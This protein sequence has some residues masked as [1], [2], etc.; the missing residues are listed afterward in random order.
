MPLAQALADFQADVQQ[1][2]SLVAHAHAT[3]PAGQSLLP[4]SDRRQITAAALLNMF[5]AWETF[6]E[7]ALAIFMTGGAT[8]GGAQPTKFVSPPSEE[9]AQSMVIGVNRYF[10]YGN[11]DFFRKLVSIYFL[12]GYPFEP[13]MAAIS[14]DLADLRTL[15]NASAHITSTTQQALE[16]LYLRI[17][18]TPNPGVDL[19]SF[20]LSLDPR[21]NAN[22]TVFLAYRNKLVV[23]AQLIAYG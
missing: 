15:R 11:H 20:L 8:L 7:R 4:L 1:C 2:E 22:E 5:V 17:F 21:S 10:D 9:A 12:N 18:G 3:D 6:L 13:H 14:G 16:S 23:A 19:Y